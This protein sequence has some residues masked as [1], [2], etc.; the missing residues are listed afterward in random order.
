MTRKL[1]KELAIRWVVVFLIA[2]LVFGP[3]VA[4]VGASLHCLI[5]FLIHKIGWQDN[6]VLKV[7]F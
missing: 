6:T 1:R 7:L 5:V 4:W 3:A 2:T